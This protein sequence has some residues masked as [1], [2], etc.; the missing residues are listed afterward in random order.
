MSP[1]AE[2]LLVSAANAVRKHQGAA[3]RSHVLALIHELEGST[4]P[5]D[6]DLVDVLRHL[7]TP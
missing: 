7:A 3:A 2:R 4:D 6:G 5:K 1:R